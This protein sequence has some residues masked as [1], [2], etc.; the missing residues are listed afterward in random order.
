MIINRF[1]NHCK[2]KERILVYIIKKEFQT[3]KELINFI[4]PSELQWKVYGKCLVCS[5]WTHSMIDK[6]T[7]LEIVKDLDSAREINITW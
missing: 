1:C 3:F 7:L 6:E 4:E 5:S 2:K